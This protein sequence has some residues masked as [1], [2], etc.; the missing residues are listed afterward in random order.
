[1]LRIIYSALVFLLIINNYALA[2]WEK[3]FEDDFNDVSLSDWM[4]INQSSSSSAK[5]EIKTGASFDG[6]NCLYGETEDCW[7]CDPDISILVNKSF[8]FAQDRKYKIELYH[9]NTSGGHGGWNRPNSLIFSV[10][11]DG[12]SFYIPE[13]EHSIYLSLYKCENG[14]CPVVVNRTELLDLGSDTWIK[15]VVEYNP[16]NSTTIFSVYDMNDNHL[17]TITTDKTPF[18]GNRVGFRVYRG[19]GYFDKLV[20][21]EWS[22]SEKCSENDLDRAKEEGYNEG[23]EAGKEYCINNPSACGIDNGDE[24]ECP[25]CQCSPTIDS[26]KASFD[27]FTNTL[28]VPCLEMGKSYWLDLELISSEPVQLELKGFGEN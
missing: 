12:K 25:I 21:Y 20:I 24:S 10:S 13:V 1:M 19:W 11:D 7:P 27:M 28:H 23:F 18:L 5:W 3:V 17:A 9:K 2:G 26:C 14:E 6:G 15:Y 8:R 4:Q 22:S 16:T